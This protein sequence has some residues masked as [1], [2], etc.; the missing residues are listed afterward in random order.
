[1]TIVWIQHRKLFDVKEDVLARADQSIKSVMSDGASNINIT[2]V[3][4]FIVEE[5]PLTSN[6]DMAIGFE[7]STQPNT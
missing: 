1:M 5:L 2:S 4:D 3:E 7:F 6:Q